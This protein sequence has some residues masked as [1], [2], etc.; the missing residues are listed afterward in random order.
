MKSLLL[1]GV[2]LFGSH[3]S[4]TAILFTMDGCPPCEI[5]KDIIIQ[6]QAEGYDVII[7]KNRQVAKEF[8]VYSFPTLIIR[9]N[10]KEILR[11]IGLLREQEYRSLIPF[12]KN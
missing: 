6:M 10:G 5:A 8:N 7:I 9:R 3:S 12:K 11:K 2:L 1:I 4:D